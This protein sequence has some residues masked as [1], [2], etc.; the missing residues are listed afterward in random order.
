MQK[1]I[2]YRTIE[3]FG[4]QENLLSLVTQT[5]AQRPNVSDTEFQAF[6]EICEVRH[7]D[8]NQQEARLHISL[9]VPG[10]RKAISPRAVGVPDGDLSVASAPE[11]TEFTERELA[12]VV[13]PNAVGYVVGGRARTSTVRA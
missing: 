4:A 2:H 5:L 8:L 9:H 7:R 6:G 10:A 13:R 3:W 12:I 11:N 1:T